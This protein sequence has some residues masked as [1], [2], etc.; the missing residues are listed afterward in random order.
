MSS[1]A[2]LQ[3][4]VASINPAKIIA[5]LA[6]YR[7]RFESPIIARTVDCC[8]GAPLIT[9]IG[10]GD[11]NFQTWRSAKYWVGI[12]SP[13]RLDYELNARP[14][15]VEDRTVAQIMRWINDS[16]HVLRNFQK[17]YPGE[18]IRRVAW[19]EKVAAGPAFNAVNALRLRALGRLCRL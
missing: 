10:Y 16:I 19:E 17:L 15:I 9:L 6:K 13:L 14:S 11:L 8:G 3:M 7:D 5:I 18:H 1:P 2:V 4:D 12:C